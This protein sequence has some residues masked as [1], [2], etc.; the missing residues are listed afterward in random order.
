M[1]FCYFC[2]EDFDKNSNVK[3]HLRIHTNMRPYKCDVCRTSFK[4]QGQLTKHKKTKKHINRLSQ[5]LKK[6][7]TPLEDQKDER[8]ELVLQKLSGSKQA[9]VKTPKKTLAFKKLGSRS[10]ELPSL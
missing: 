2:D 8:A 6:K 4:Q 10:H 1:Y 9:F 5:M 3:D 7:M